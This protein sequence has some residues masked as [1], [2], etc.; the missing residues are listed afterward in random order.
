MVK[1]IHAIYENG[2][3]RP[4]EKLDLK[5][6]QRLKITLEVLPSVVEETQALIRARAEVVKEVAER[7]EYLPEW[8]TP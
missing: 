3:L 5:E 7:E 8:G 6:S 4:L 1:T 2:V